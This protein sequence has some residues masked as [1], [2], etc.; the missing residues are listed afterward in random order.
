MMNNY[1]IL[2]KPVEC[3]L[4]NLFEQVVFIRMIGSAEKPFSEI[5]S[6]YWQQ[7]LSDCEFLEKDQIWL[8]Q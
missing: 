5:E 1:Q 2:V 4:N 6:F 7:F 8:N 3:S